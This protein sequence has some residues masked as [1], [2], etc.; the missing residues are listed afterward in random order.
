LA[1]VEGD[2]RSGYTF[3][4]GCGT[5]QESDKTPG[6]HNPPVLADGDVPA[7]TSDEG[8][9][10]V[11]VGGSVSGVIDFTGDVDTITVT[12]V[13]GQTYSFSL[14]GSG[15]TPVTDTFLSIFSPA[16]V[17]LNEDDDG[18][19]GVYSLITITAA[20]SGVYTL[21][22]ESF[23]NPG[24]PGLGDWTLSVHQMGADE[25]P[26][27]PP[28]AVPAAVGTTTY[29]FLQTSGDD[30]VYSVTLTAGF[31][32]DFSVAGG[33]DYNTDWQ[34]VPAGELDTIIRVYD[35][36]G[37]LLFT[38]DDV[39]F[40]DDI[41]SSLGFI[42]ETSG[43]YY[44]E[45]EAYP[46]QTGGYTL[47]ISE[48][49]LSTLDPLDAIDWGGP[50]NAVDNSDTLLI[51]FATAGQTYDGVTDIGGWTPYMQAQALAAFQTY[52]Q[53]A[54]LTFAI[55]TDTN[56]ADFHLV[57]TTSTQF[58]AYFN[59]PG[60]TNAGVGVFATNGTGWDSTGAAG[61]MEP[62]GYGWITLIHEFGHG[63]GMA[64]PHDN[65]GG[66]DV[67]PGVTGPFGSYGIFDMNQ[68]VYTTMS[69]NDGWQIHPDTDANGFPVPDTLDYGYQGTPMALDIAL[70]QIKYGS[71]AHNIGNNVYTLG[72]AN[73][74]GTYYQAIWDTGGTDE[75]NYVGS[76]D[77]VIDL[78]AATLDYSA[79]GAG[80]VS[81]VDGIFGGYTIANGVTIENATGGS[82]N[83]S[84]V[85]NAIANVL[86]GNDGNDTFFGGFG[87]DTIH[88]GNG[89]DTAVFLGNQADYTITPLGGGVY[90]VTDNVAGNGDEGTDT[91][92]GVRFLQFADGAVNLEDAPGNQAPT[93]TGLN[94]TVVFNENT[95]NAAAQLIDGD[96]TFDDS[97]G[98]F[99]GGTVTVAG[100]LAEDVI[101]IRNEGTGVGQIGVSGANVTYGGVIIGTF[102]GGTGGTTLT[103]TLNAAA[104]SVA[105]DQLL[106][107]LTYAN[108]NQDPTLNRTLTINVTDSDG[109]SLA[110]PVFTPGPYVELTGA[111]DPFANPGILPTFGNGPNFAFVDVNN[112]GD[113]DIVVGD[114]AGTL[115]YFEKNGAA[116]TEVIGVANPFNGFDPGSYTTPALM[117]VDGDGD[118]DLVVGSNA[119]IFSTFRN[120]GNGTWTALAGVANPFNGLTDPSF[121]DPAAIDVDGDG[122]IDMIA[123]SSYG[124]MYSFLNNGSGVFTMHGFGDPLNPFGT[125]DVGG[126]SSPATGD[127]DGDGDLDVIIGVGNGATG[128]QIRTFINNGGGSFTE[129]VGAGINPFH[130]IDVG[131]YALPTLAD[132]DGDGDAD[133]V[134]GDSSGGD[135]RVWQNTS[136]TTPGAAPTV[137]ITVNSQN[138]APSGANNSHTINENASYQYT[139]ADF[140]FTDV[141]AD[142]L[143]AVVVTTLPTNGQ[144]QLNGVAVTLGQVV[145]AA[146]ITAG[147]LDFVPDANE[148]GTG[149]A[150]W[151]FQV[152]DNGGTANGGVDTDPSANTMTVNVTPDNTAPTLAGFGPSVT[153]LENT[154]NAA[155]QILDADVT[156]TD[157]EGNF[158]GGSLEVSGL[159]AEDSV[160]INNQ[161]V[162]AGQIGVSGANVTYGG[163]V[164]GTFSG[165]TAGSDLVVT[166]NAAAT[167][168]AVDALIQNLTYANS[169]NNPTASRELTLNVTDSEGLDLVLPGGFNEAT[170][171]ADPLAGL[172]AFGPGPNLAFVDVNNDGDLDIVVGD[173]DGTLRY[174]ENNGAGYTEVT[175][176]SNPFDG[177]VGET[178][179]GATP[180]L[181]TAPCTFDIDGDGDL[182]IVVGNNYGYFATV[183]NNGNGTWTQLTGAANPLDGIA[184]PLFSDP[185]AIDY[186][187]DGDMDI[188]AGSSYGD[189]YAIRNDGGGSFTLTSGLPFDVGSFSSAASGDVDGDGDLDLVVGEADGTINTF[190]NNGGGVF[191]QALGAANPFNGIDV[192]SYS[193]PTLVDIDGDGDDDLVVADSSGGDTRVFLNNPGGAP[194]IVVN[195]TPEAD[196]V[197]LYDTGDVLVGTFG[198][199]QEAIDAAS[200]GY[201]ISAL[202]GT[203]NENIVVDVDVTI[204]GANVGVAGT[205]TR[206]AETIIDGRI[207]ISADGVTIDGVRIV[208]DGGGPLGTTGVVVDSGSDNF[209]I[210]NSVLDGDGDFALF[211]GL[212]SGLD[213]G[214]NL[215]QGYSIG[216][217]I[218]GGATSG[219]VHDNLFQGDGG[220]FTGLG[221][222]VNSETSHVLIQNNTF[223]GLYSGVL[224]LFPFGP[225]PVDL[226]SYVIGNTLTGNAAPRPVQVYPTVDS[227][228][229]VGTDYNE[230]FNG[231]IAG[232]ASG[233]V[234]TFD[235]Q[236]GDDHI[237]GFDAGDTLLGGDGNDRI[238]A[239]GGN[240]NLTGGLGGDLIYGE[241]GTDTANFAG[242]LGYADTVLGW[243]VSSSIDGNDILDGV[244]IVIDGEGQ[245]NLLVGAT[246]YASTQVAL[247]AAQDG[248]NIRL[249]T[250]NYTGTYTYDE[251]DLSIIAQPGAVLNATFSTA[252]TDGISVTGGASAD[253][254]TTDDGDDTLNGGGGND[255]LNG[256]AGADAMAGGDGNDIFYVDQ[257]GDSVSELTGQGTRDVVYASASFALG[258]GSAVEVLSTT[259]SAGTTAINLTGN[260]LSQ[261]L[262][263]NAGANVLDGRGGIDY[264]FG[265]GG[266][267]LYYVDVAGDVVGEAAGEGRDVVY[268]SASYTLAAG[269]E[270]EVL[271][272]DNYDGTSALA[273]TGNGIANE[274]FGNA[275]ANVLDG[276]GGADYLRGFGGNDLYYVDDA[277]DIVIEQGGEGRDVVYASASYT[278]TAGQE[279]EVLSTTSQAGTG[280][281]D[282]TGNGGINE[283]Y[284]NAGANAINGGDGSDY[285]MGFGGADTFAFT[286]A[287]GASNVDQILDF[288]VADDT[289]ALDD[290]VFTGL[291]PG[292]LAAGA[293]VNGTAAGDADDRILYNSAT[294]Q[295][296][297]DADG[298]GAGAAVLFATVSAGTVLT[299]SD[300]TVI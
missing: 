37:T 12:L 101:A 161:G 283:I 288:N 41:S 264:M 135:T 258:A 240:D 183:Q 213:V 285:L 55:T 244:E 245:R 282:L 107:N 178:G 8:T 62:G 2:P 43:T 155:P 127:V 225:N 5:C 232:L 112:D 218:A 184:D 56:L 49:D 108:A 57:T 177:F 32:Y 280:A 137:Q 296:Y 25:A 131:A 35:S 138:D 15:G 278:L 171:G 266:N 129:A 143:L 272:S 100:A 248:D 243:V 79:T 219:S 214:D 300:F 46:G 242:T 14:V 217:Y 256:A 44:V 141:D 246:A 81:W 99:D 115:R 117:D 273:L 241:G 95:V 65:G 91:I 255:V 114:Q 10:N 186:D 6:S 105:V 206:G 60:E 209:S 82:G 27:A 290:A 199:I 268:A 147:L 277:G 187:G 193:I 75:I 287:L 133:L 148:F 87:N 154:V 228:N 96:V 239:Q 247:D 295:L 33:A 26:E 97:D 235:G 211:V 140:G 224:N 259:S 54:D 126:F 253:N 9:L 238:F 24:D 151:T 42:P 121:S 122:D 47:D 261:E 157:A 194:T 263:G 204:Q 202:A 227:T 260:E 210:V 119:G 130:G 195:V 152:R 45:V 252:G 291:T 293:F 173:Q 85:G 150:T 223:D 286:T 294:G 274:I 29:G 144:L 28:S 17:L 83:D 90:T 66:S 123:G 176:A 36:A 120:N 185:T 71:V 168:A 40:P 215:I 299:A 1:A 111:N 172:P 63:L 292:A 180:S 163:V 94:P 191:T 136:T 86:T 156:F 166:L 207:T 201:R 52:S 162:A 98:N 22:A 165:G 67:M 118:Q 267:D 254:I 175:G 275:G 226:D 132:I 84:L 269:S 7:D 134:V 265:F 229:I 182:D 69:Y 61:S 20:T 169:S 203:Y 110:A 164:I 13:A 170:G 153:F 103:V 181:Y 74:A 270:I 31:I 88:G 68:G 16:A 221:N 160:G 189:L 102:A 276:G 113:L 104:T 196:P 231:D 92:D 250:G 142:T 145:S 149:Y 179:G 212:V 39:A 106:E 190:I 200:D 124:D 76:S 281:I 279:I 146:D 262:Y 297:F 53:F 174:F 236:G 109:A 198:T 237:Y 249:A 51:Y 59:P 58:L 197:S 251:S 72:A 222:G 284:G 48:T 116:Y 38:N 192:G 18:G 23:A 208:G 220:P 70:M 77:A 80:V 50:L 30:D 19:N 230:A 34:A 3:C 188:V 298:N 78:T 158:N 64:H 159:L 271:S 289:I 205:D 93:L 234:L 139:L 89:T 125:L 167:S 21:T 73:V 216:M 128:G 233:T 11:T 257:A 4:P